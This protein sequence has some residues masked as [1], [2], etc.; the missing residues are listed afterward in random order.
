MG[1][2]ELAEEIIS[3][4]IRYKLIRNAKR[5]LLAKN[6]I[7]ERLGDICF[8]ESLIHIFILKTKFTEV[9]NDRLKKL[10]VELE[11]V[12]LDLEYD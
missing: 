2:K 5:L 10:L 11:R 12:R 4:C 9:D 8:V 3:F 7:E 1:R 6:R